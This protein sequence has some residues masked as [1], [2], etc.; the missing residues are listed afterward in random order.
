[1]STDTMS[2]KDLLA[3]WIV[4]N[5]EHPGPADAWVLPGHVSEWVVIGQLQLDHG[6]SEAVTEAY[7]LPAEGVRAAEAY[8]RQHQGP[9][10]ARIAEHRAAFHRR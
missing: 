1:M 6:E 8:Y 2:E 9:I 4:P 10:D 7:D 3:H 5:P